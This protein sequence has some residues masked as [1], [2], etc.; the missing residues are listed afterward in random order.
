MLRESSFNQASKHAVGLSF[1]IEI[2]EDRSELLL[3]S[4]QHSLSSMLKREDSLDLFRL[5]S[6]INDD[7]SKVERPYLWSSGGHACSN[8]HW[9]L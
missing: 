1:D 4:N 9:S 5:G 3:V 8:D 7:P 2:F 6:L